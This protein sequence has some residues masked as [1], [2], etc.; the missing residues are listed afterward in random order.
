VRHTVNVSAI[1]I[2]RQLRRRRCLHKYEFD[3]VTCAIG[4]DYTAL[5]MMKN[6]VHLS[7]KLSEQ[8]LSDVRH[9]IR[10]KWYWP[11]LLA[12]NWYGLTLF[13]IVIWATVEG[14][15]G[16]IHPNWRALGIMWGI[17][18]F[19]FGW[20]YL[21]T[22]RAMAKQ[23]SNLSTTLPEWITVADDGV[24][25]DGPN[26]AKVFNPWRAFTG[27]REG[28]RVILL[29]F[30]GGAFLILPVGEKSDIE[31]E[32]LRQFLRSQLLPTTGKPVTA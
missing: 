17:V 25:L 5:G 18:L 7:G 27:W 3:E 24:Q 9:V 12:A 31:R 19:L 1:A 10:S 30:A 4:F 14:I 26:G 2:Y 8:D 20:A 16:T 11:K 32:F 6:Q 22:R 13:G 29:D 28:N 15:I 21:S 23:F